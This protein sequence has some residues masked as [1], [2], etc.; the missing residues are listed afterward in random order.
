[1]PKGVNKDGTNNIAKYNASTT[2]EQKAAQQRAASAAGVAARKKQA[3][4]I[5]D[6]KT[7]AKIV[8]NAPA[9]ADLKAALKRLGIENENL[10][11][12][13]GIVL[14]V[15]QAALN[16]DMKAVEKW[17]SYVGQADKSKGGSAA[18]F[19]QIVCDLPRPTYSAPPPDTIVV[20]AE[21]VSD[22][23]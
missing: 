15:Y 20:E 21:E 19:V 1:M 2:P 7:I 23:G 12:A 22:S 9:G 11:N 6:I 10:T 13:A 14:A 5:K 8:N 4:Q 18:P 3:K 16:G 17:E